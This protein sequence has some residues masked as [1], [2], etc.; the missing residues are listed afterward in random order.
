MEYKL[1]TLGLYVKELS[2]TLDS[3][4]GENIEIT[5]KI[6]LV[7]K[8]LFVQESCILWVISYFVYKLRKRGVY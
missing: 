7:I 3:R 1:I 2:S 6:F 5:L 8:N 4:W